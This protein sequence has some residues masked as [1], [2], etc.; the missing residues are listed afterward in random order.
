MSTVPVLFPPPP[1]RS[2]KA[3]TK[4]DKRRVLGVLDAVH[5]GHPIVERADVLRRR[6]EAA[7][8]RHFGSVF[9]PGDGLTLDPPVVVSRLFR[10]AAERIAAAWD[11]KPPNFCELD[12]QVKHAF[13]EP[14]GRADD[15]F[16]ILDA[17][18]LDRFDLPSAVEH[19]REHEK[20]QAL[21][22]R[23]LR[24]AAEP[25]FDDG[26]TIDDLVE[27]PRRVAEV[28]ETKARRTREL[29][30]QAHA[31]MAEQC[32]GWRLL[33]LAYEGSAGSLE[34]VKASLP[35]TVE[36][37]F[38]RA[39]FSDDVR[40]EVHGLGDAGPYVG[41]WSRSEREAQT[42]LGRLST[43]VVE[44]PAAN[45]SPAEWFARVAGLRAQGLSG[46]PWWE[47]APDL[48]RLPDV[49]RR[50]GMERLAHWLDAN[51]PELSR[52]LHG[53]V[54]H[55]IRHDTGWETL[56]HKAR[57]VKSADVTR[58]D[59]GP[60]LLSELEGR[61][62]GHSVDRE[63]RSRPLVVVDPGQAP[64]FIGL[65]QRDDVGPHDRLL[66]VEIAYRAGAELRGLIF[67]P[68]RGRWAGEQA[69]VQGGPSREVRV[70]GEDGSLVLHD[71]RSA[72]C[73]RMPKVTGPLVVQHARVKRGHDVLVCGTTVNRPRAEGRWR[74]DVRT[75]GIVVESCPSEAGLLRLTP[76]VGWT[77]RL[78]IAPTGRYRRLEL[79][80]SAP[81]PMKGQPPRP[82]S[83]V[84]V[85]A[86]R[87][88]W[89]SLVLPYDPRSMVP[90]P[91]VRD[92][93]RSDALV[94]V[95]VEAQR[96][97][98][99]FNPG[100]LL[101]QL[102]GVDDG[103][104]VVVEERGRLVVVSGRARALGLLGAPAKLCNDN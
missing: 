73:R 57:P 28:W 69:H 89:S 92:S 29:H 44:L 14:L 23:L 9:A 25:R 86:A 87:D 33:E 53:L 7:L 43:L 62:R 21:A 50:A 83:L 63:W 11:G 85:E 32:Q 19:L 76:A 8:G 41:P 99:S 2:W 55:R 38:T 51:Q 70:R 91:L 35:S 61:A 79:G 12:E 80:P 31:Q 16:R 64:V 90:N 34:M 88:G 30:V 82:S 40:A 66:D 72:N 39:K 77:T 102:P 75:R 1:A 94:P 3:Y 71:L 37:K 5:A 103:P 27:N 97:Q 46:V 48:G 98:A 60:L 93:D 67:D 52:V 36:A 24:L 15:Y 59:V 6:Y 65:P 13:Y 20:G 84:L 10:Q 100:F 74:V 78:A 95:K 68:A 101:G 54:R 81:V 49:A 45:M 56:V 18:V 26:P 42:A 4:A 17:I 47:S 96:I 58:L 22:R 104:P